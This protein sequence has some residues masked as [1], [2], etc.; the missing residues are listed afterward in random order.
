M[1]W[2]CEGWIHFS[3]MDSNFEVKAHLLY[4]V[5]YNATEVMDTRTVTICRGVWQ[6]TNLILQSLP[7]LTVRRTRYWHFIKVNTD[8]SKSKQN[9][10]IYTNRLV[11]PVGSFRFYS[12]GFYLITLIQLQRFSLTNSNISANDESG[13]FGRQWWKLLLKCCLRVSWR[14]REAT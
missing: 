4:P 14:L 7:G 11:F 3:G 8:L 2:R 12:L 9:V 1:R 10:C 6:T 5:F 13:G